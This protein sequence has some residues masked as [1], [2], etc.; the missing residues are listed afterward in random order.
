MD[1]FEK[2]MIG[3]QMLSSE[4]QRKSMI[5]DMEQCICPDCPT[6]NDCAKNAMEG[7]FCAHGTSFHCIS[8][9]KDCICPSCPIT[10]QYGLT[11]NFFCTRGSEAA[12]RLAGWVLSQK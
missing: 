2:S 7:L 12:Q 1:K 10:E 8:E 11:R 4:E 9:E 6:Y 3:F 5:T